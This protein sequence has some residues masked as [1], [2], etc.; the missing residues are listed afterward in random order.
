MHELP[1]QYGLVK[2]HTESILSFERSKDTISYF[3]FLKRINMD[4]IYDIRLLECIGRIHLR[5]KMW[6]LCVCL[7]VVHEPRTL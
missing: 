4:S 2:L 3:S 7:E 1:L 6:N 5:E